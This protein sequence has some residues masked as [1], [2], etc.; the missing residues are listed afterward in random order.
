MP[1]LVGAAASRVPLASAL[2]TGPADSAPAAP[3]LVGPGLVGPGLAA[4]GPAGGGPAEA[5]G[6]SKQSA[7]EGHSRW[8]DQQAGLYGRIG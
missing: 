5:L 2:R 8:I 1:P 3:G 7:W 6:T 4:P